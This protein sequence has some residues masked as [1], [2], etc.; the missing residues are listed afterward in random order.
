MDTCLFER[1]L[2]FLSEPLL[3]LLRR[4]QRA[5][6]LVE[7]VTMRLFGGLGSSRYSR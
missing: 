7:L 1:S 2:T 3:L 5:T 6:E 4:K